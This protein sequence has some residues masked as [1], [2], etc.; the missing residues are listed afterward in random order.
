MPVHRAIM[1]PL[2][3]LLLALATLLLLLLHPNGAGGQVADDGRCD[4]GRLVYLDLGVNWANTLRLYQELGGCDGSSP[5]WEIYG[6][7]AMPLMHTYIEA[8]MAW[9]NGQ[10]AKPPM[11]L[12]PAGSSVDLFKFA[13]KYGC[14]RAPPVRHNTCAS[15]CKKCMAAKLH[16]KLASLHPEPRLTEPSFIASRMAAAAESHPGRGG[17]GGGGEDARPRYTF[18]PSAV[19]AANTTIEISCHRVGLIHGGGHPL[20]QKHYPNSSNVPDV[21]RQER[22]R[23]PSIDVVGWMTTNFELRDWI[24]VKMD[25]EG[26]EFEIFDS[27]AKLGKTCLVDILVWQCHDFNPYGRTCRS[28]KR[29]IQTLCPGIVIIE[30]DL[31]KERYGSTREKEAP[32]YYRGI[33]KATRREMD[34]DLLAEAA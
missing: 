24:V 31:K 22:F 7:E 18:I 19:G 1:S 23:V 10:G 14:D 3:S 26:A 16:G 27:F 5:R 28:L 30:E 9:L 34:N 20:D 15:G 12:P 32:N 2:H 8:F 11:E 6:F 4:A 29:N 13:Q 33:D 17:G 21:F 25:V